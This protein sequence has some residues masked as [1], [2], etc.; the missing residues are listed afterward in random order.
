MRTMFIQMRQSNDA[1]LK[2]T[3]DFL[4]WYSSQRNGFMIKSVSFVLA[5]LIDEI[6][7]MYKEIAS[8][9][10]IEIFSAGCKETVF[11]DRN[12]LE[13]ILRNLLDN[14]IKY[15]EQGSVTISCRKTAGSI[16]IRVEDTGPGIPI[17]IL[18]QL[19]MYYSLETQYSLATFG[20]RFIFTLSQKIGALLYVTNKKGSGASITIVL[21]IT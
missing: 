17:Q 1:I 4:T 14:A 19:E 7:L 6:L 2:F 20:Y 9:K 18:E 16:S 13:V 11:T 3:Q 15:T 5:G 8:L 12:I 10:N 21:P